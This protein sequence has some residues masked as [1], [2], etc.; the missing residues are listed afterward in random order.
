MKIG[1]SMLLICISLVF[2]NIAYSNCGRCGNDTKAINKQTTK[3]SKVNTLVTSIPDDGKINGLVI[4]SCG[5]CNLG[6]KKN[7][8][9]SL[10]IKIGDTIY[11]VSGTDIHAHGNAHG[12]EGFCSAIRVAWAHGQI[13][14]KVFHSESF[15]LVGSIE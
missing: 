10:S 12:K 7:K 1:N 9:C 8:G 4:T 15:Q 2:Y 3:A 11:P 5:K 6:V 14:E 13:K